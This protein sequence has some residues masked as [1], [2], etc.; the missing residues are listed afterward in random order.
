[1]IITIQDIG[2]LK[3]NL[4]DATK[5]ERS[6]KSQYQGNETR[7]RRRIKLLEAKRNFHDWKR[8]MILE[9]VMQKHG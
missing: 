5:E 1:M 2:V 3:R 7:L 4:K 8:F 6:K 9:E